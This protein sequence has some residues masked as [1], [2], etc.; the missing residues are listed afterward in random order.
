MASNNPSKI[1]L[2]YLRLKGYLWNLEALGGRA[3]NEEYVPRL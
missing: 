3:V 2:V 1:S